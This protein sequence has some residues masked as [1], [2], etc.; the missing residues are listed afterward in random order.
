[1]ATSDSTNFEPNVTEFVE[2]AFERCGLELRTGYDLVSAKRS[3]NLMLAE[4]ANRGLNQWTIEEATQTVTE[5]TLT[6]TLDSNVIDILD[7][8]LRRTDGNVTTDLSMRRLSRSE[9][10]NIP[11][12]ATTGRPSQFFLDKQNA[13]VLKIWPAPENSTDVLV[14]NKLVRMDDADTAINTM[15]MPFRF[16][17]CFAAGL[18]YYIS[19]K[20]APEKSGMLKQMYEEE[21]ERASST[22]EDRASFRIRPYIS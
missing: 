18:A 2:E 6:Y 3:I 7:C 12:K 17:P 13:P 10:L 22:D 20:K 19:V 16:Y 21:F 15:D 8:N 1:M 14:F 9:Y 11:V 5:N 4:W